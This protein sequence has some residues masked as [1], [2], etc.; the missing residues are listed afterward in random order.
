LPRG[1]PAGAMRAD[2]QDIGIKHHAHQALLAFLLNAALRPDLAN[3]AIDD[4]VELVR[5]GVGITRLDVRHGAV[6][7]APADGLL[8]KF[9]AFFHALGAEVSAQREVDF[10]GDFNIPANSF[11]R[12]TPIHTNR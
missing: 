8:D 6:E 1:L 12:R 5:V 10:P 4:G 3:G 7:D 2:T 9:L 11:S